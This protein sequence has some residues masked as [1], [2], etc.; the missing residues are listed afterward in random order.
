LVQFDGCNTSAT[1]RVVVI[2]ATNRPW[3]LDEAVMRR[4]VNII[5][6]HIIIIIIIII[7]INIIIAVMHLLLII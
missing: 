7:I 3:D 5:I 1:D 6:M 4:L 2:G